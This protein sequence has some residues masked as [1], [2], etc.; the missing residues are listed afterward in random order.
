MREVPVRRRS[1]GL[2][3][4]MVLTACGLHVALSIKEG[5]QRCSATI[6]T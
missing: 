2:F 4:C 3:T 1:K 6:M 5:P